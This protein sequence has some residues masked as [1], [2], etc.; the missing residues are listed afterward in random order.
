MK[1]KGVFHDVFTD[2]FG[3]FL[4]GLNADYEKKTY[5]VYTYIY[6]ISVTVPLI[7]PWFFHTAL[8]CGMSKAILSGQV[9]LHAFFNVFSIASVL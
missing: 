3:I 9:D 8:N 4:N 6:L 1:H 5:V 7:L 2:N